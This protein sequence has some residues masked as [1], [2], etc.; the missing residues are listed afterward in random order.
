MTLDENLNLFVLEVNSNPYV[1][2][3]IEMLEILLKDVAE[4]F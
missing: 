2:T 3:K 1:T 4:E